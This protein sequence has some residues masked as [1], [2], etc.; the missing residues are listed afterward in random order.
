MVQP[1]PQCG[2]NSGAKGDAARID[3]RL[4]AG[5]NYR[6]DVYYRQ[7]TGRSRGTLSSDFD[8]ETSLKAF[9]SSAT[10]ALGVERRMGCLR[11]RTPIADSSGTSIELSGNPDDDYLEPVGGAVCEFVDGLAPVVA[12]ASFV[13]SEPP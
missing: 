1:D 10:A 11:L 2:G 3:M 13:E 7:S 4:H 12:G 9:L 5:D 6:K 8:V